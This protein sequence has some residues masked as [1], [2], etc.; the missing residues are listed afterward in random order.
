M[1]SSSSSSF[2]PNPFAFLPLTLFLP[3]YSP[4]LLRDT[5][6]QAIPNTH[7]PSGEIL[8]PKQPWTQA[9]AT[10]SQ[11]SGSQSDSDGAI[12]HLKGPEFKAGSEAAALEEEEEREAV[13]QSW[14]A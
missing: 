6:L 2:F 3:E 13:R 11:V 9:A 10:D 12:R 14:G 8:N 4:A 5:R 7:P 1:N